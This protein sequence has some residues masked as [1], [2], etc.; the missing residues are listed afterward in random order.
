MP[1]RVPVIKTTLFSAITRSPYEDAD[2]ISERLDRA[3]RTGLHRKRPLVGQRQC[4]AKRRLHLPF[5][6]YNQAHKVHRIENRLRAQESRFRR[7]NYVAIRR[8]FAIDPINGAVDRDKDVFWVV[9]VLVSGYSP[10]E[11]R[12]LS[13]AHLGSYPWRI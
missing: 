10:L 11:S 6:R 2:V 4:D 8:Q 3:E 9:H 5:N 1:F 7:L 12:R 13:R